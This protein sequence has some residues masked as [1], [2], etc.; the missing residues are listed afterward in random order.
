VDLGSTVAIQPHERPEFGRA[1]RDYFEL[2][3]SL[4]KANGALEEQDDQSKGHR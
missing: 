4:T 2:V 3:E 1:G